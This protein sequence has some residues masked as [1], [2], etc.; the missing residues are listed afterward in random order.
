MARNASYNTSNLIIYLFRAYK[1]TFFSIPFSSKP[2]PDIDSLMQEWPPQIEDIL[3]ETGIPTA[4]F[5]CDVATYVDII[6]ALLDIP[7]YKS[8]IQSLHVFF[9]LY[10]AFKHSQ[11]FNMMAHEEAMEFDES[12]QMLL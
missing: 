8:R 2:M 12:N 6:C 10:S 5:D 3:R 11:H 4:D 7:V 9:S 1:L